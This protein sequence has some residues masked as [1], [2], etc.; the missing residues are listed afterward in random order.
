MLHNLPEGRG[1]YFL[2][3]PNMNVGALGELISTKSPCT[4]DL[5]MSQRHNKKCIEWIYCIFVKS[6]CYIN[7]ILPLL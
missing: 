4:G 6:L 5:E 2:T 1:Y 3:S 7:F